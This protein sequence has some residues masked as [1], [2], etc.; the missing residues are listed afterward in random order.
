MVYSYIFLQKKCVFPY[1][2]NFTLMY[3]PFSC[4][5]AVLFG[6]ILLENCV[7]FFK[8]SLNFKAHALQMELN[9]V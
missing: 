9:K 8:S 1:V 7:V 2:G 3:S 6:P 5:I 4:L